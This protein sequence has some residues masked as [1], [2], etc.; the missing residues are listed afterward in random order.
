[1]ERK[2]IEFEVENLIL[3]GSLY[4]PKPAKP[5]AVL[6][7]HGWTGQPNEA[8][9]KALAK[10]GFAAMTFSLSGH[11]D[12]DG[13]IEDQTRQKSLKQVKAAYDLF[14]DKLAKD[15][16]IGCAGSSY[17]S[18]MAMLLS[19]ERPLVCLSLRVPANYPDERFEEA[20]LPQAA[21]HND[22]K[23]MQWREQ[24]LDADET[25]SL[26]AL[27]NF[28]G[29]IQVIEAGEDEVV[30]NQTVQNYVDAVGDTR[31]LQYHYMGDWPHGLGDD[32]RRNQQYQELLLSWL[33]QQV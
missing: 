22:P 1:M 9:A 6:F 29:K 16:K 23:I 30:P 28:K 10:D 31:T 4:L 24:I 26:Q 18:Y 3:R 25:R 17:G 19:A 8:A 7:I 33:R 13:K 2:P 5:L 14:K 12:S 11:N 27:N 21:D 20:Q 32:P 15:I